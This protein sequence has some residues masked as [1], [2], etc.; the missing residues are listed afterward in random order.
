M[1]AQWDVAGL[2]GDLPKLRVPSL[3]LVGAGDRAVPPENFRSR[4]RPDRGGGVEELP[5]LGHL[6]HEE[7]PDLA[8]DAIRRFLNRD[9]A[10]NATTG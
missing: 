3:L 7:A 9:R 5:G 2:T 8:A 4:C 6:L 1:M 10:E